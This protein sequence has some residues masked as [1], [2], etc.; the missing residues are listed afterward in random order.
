M[1]FKLV[2]T[3]GR[4]RVTEPQLTIR[5]N[6]VVGLNKKALELA[7]GSHVEVYYDADAGLVGFKFLAEKSEQSIKVGKAGFSAKSKLAEFMDFDSNK[8]FEVV[9]DAGMLVID[10][11]K[12]QV[13]ASR[14]SKKRDEAEGAGEEAEPG[15]E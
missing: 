10:L 11:T 15:E 4:V 3:T 2:E 14:Q 1:A 6:G 12:G 5:T 13:L 8:R 9:E 7:K